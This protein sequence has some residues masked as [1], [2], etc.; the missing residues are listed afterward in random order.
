MILKIALRNF[1]KNLKIS[2]VVILGLAISLSLVTGALSL[3]DSINVWKWERIEENFGNADAVAEPKSPS[4]LFF[5]FATSKIDDSEIENLKKQVKGVLPVSEDSARLNNSLDVLVIATE[6]ESLSDF[7]GESLTL[8]PG[9]AIVGKSVA[10]LMNLKVGD[11]I[12]LLFSSGSREFTIVKIGEEGFLNFKGESAS[13]P[14]TVFINAE[15]FPSGVFPTKC[16]LYYS[17]PIEKHEETNIETNLRV[18]NIKYSF[19]KSPI[20]R[21]L[22]YVTLAFSGI[23][24]FVGF[25][26]FYMFCEDVMRDRSSTLVTLRKIGLRK[27]EEWGILLLE[28]FMYSL[29][30]AAAGV[31]IGIFVGKFLLS[32]F[33][34][35]VD[36]ISSSFFHVD[37]I[38]FHLSIR[39][40][41]LSLGLGVLFPMILFLLKA[42]EITGKPPVYRE[43]GEQLDVSWKLLIFVVFLGLVLFFSELRVFSV[44]LLSLVIAIKLKNPFI[45][46]A[47]GTLNLGMGFFS[48][49]NLQ[50]ERDFILS[51]LNKGSAIFFGVTLLVF[52]VVLLS[53]NVFNNLMSKG[54]L[55]LLIGLSYVQRFPKKGITVSLTFAFLIF[56][57]TVF[58]IL[59]ASADRFVQEK[60]RGGLFGYNFLVLENPFRSLL[61]KTSLPLHEELK[62]PCRVYLYTL[63]T[64]KGE[65][66]IAFVDESFFRNS[67]LKLL[68]GSVKSLEA[69]DTVLIGDPVDFEEI[70]GTLKSIL[71]LGGREDVKFKIAGVYNKNDYLVPIDMIAPISN[72]ASDVKPLSLLLGK[73]EKSSASNV[74]QFYLSKFA[75]PFFLDEEFKKLYSGIEGLV[76]VIRF[77]F[78]FGFL[79][80]SSGL[81]LFVLKSYF[82]RVK[83]MG[84]LRAVGMKIN[85]LVTSFLIEHLFFLFGGILIGTVSGV[86]VGYFVS[87]AMSESLG[88]FMV[89]VPVASILLSLLTVVA[90]ASAVMVIPSFMMSKLS[91]LEA[92][93]EGE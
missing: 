7:V 81:L 68:R 49:L 60:V 65:K 91:P 54:N 44:V 70:T 10:R 1:T 22:A 2:L 62:D 72:A 47:L 9:E 30:S 87:E 80:A 85:Q 78:L 52:S 93:R 76:S 84:T 57:V 48:D 61:A 16:Y 74:K 71:P 67:T 42:R 15:D 37:K 63:K 31:L 25:L 33:Q 73:V 40:L 90:L 13:L 86:L 83:I 4:F 20:N 69:S 45:M 38:V 26:V 18:R 28:G 59:S 14:G 92:M 23:S 51:S 53:K 56:S 8:N 17:L 55:S 19:L 27:M 64:E 32:R 11:R 58:N 75:Y 29:I 41:F 66:M 21:S 77:I 89:S 3:S 43:M 46:M 6:P 34:E 36:V 35:V 50:S 82:S 39:T 5:S 79:S 88:T 12:T 24:I